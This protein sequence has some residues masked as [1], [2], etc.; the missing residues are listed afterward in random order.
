MRCGGQHIGP[1]HSSESA[2]SFSAS[3]S[4]H[5]Q[6]NA[7]ILKA[8]ISALGWLITSYTRFLSSFSPAVWLSFHLTV[9]SSQAMQWE[10]TGFT[11]VRSEDPV[12]AT[13]NLRLA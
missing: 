12:G 11:G 13:G 2:V 5:S 3:V 7:S 9:S 4:E 10:S 8:A 1:G 6:Y